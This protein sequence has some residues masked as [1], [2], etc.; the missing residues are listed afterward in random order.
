MGGASSQNGEE[1]KRKLFQVYFL[2]VGEKSFDC[3]GI[4]GF[5][6]KCRKST[7][8]YSTL[9]TAC[10]FQWLATT[11]VHEVH[12]SDVFMCTI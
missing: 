3:G 4:L 8:I 2:G 6:Y 9:E 12:M 11:S 5:L 10:L 1:Q 7:S